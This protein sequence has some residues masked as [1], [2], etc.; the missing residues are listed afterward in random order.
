[1]YPSAG[2]QSRQITAR[3]SVQV[4]EKPQARIAP[5]TGH[6]DPSQQD[7]GDSQQDSQQKEDGNVAPQR[8]DPPRQVPDQAAESRTGHAG[9]GA[10]DPPQPDEGPL[11]AGDGQ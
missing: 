6:V 4:F 11:P 3:G 9:K 5:E 10:G 8:R 1:M 2:Q 7:Q